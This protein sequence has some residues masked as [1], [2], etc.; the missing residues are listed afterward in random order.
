MSAPETNALPPA[1]VST[2]TRTSLSAANMASASVVASHISER[3]GIVPLGIVEGHEADAR[4]LAREHLVG[5]RHFFI[6]LL[7]RRT[8]LP[9]TTLAGG[10]CS[11]IGI[12]GSSPAMTD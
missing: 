12:A 2:T 6:L 9:C 4:F 5:L 3:H 1:P 11:T 8:Q 10:S 7:T